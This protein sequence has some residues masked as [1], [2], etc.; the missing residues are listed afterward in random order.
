[1]QGD[2]LL[3]GLMLVF[4]CAAFLFGLVYVLC[5]LFASVGRGI[6][7]LVRPLGRVGSGG[8]LSLGRGPLVC[9]RANCRK[10]E[11][12]NARFCSQCGA[13]LLETHAAPPRAQ[14]PTWWLG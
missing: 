6:W 5:A 2:L 10:A 14:H 7:G 8:C 4:G 9:P 3:V 11:Y 1:V 12:R 13:R